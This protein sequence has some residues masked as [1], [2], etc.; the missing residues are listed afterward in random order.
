MSSS[1]PNQNEKYSNQRKTYAT[2]GD[3]WPRKI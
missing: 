3:P 2:T 1:T